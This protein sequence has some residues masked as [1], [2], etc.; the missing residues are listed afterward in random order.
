MNSQNQGT[1]LTAE[2]HRKFRDS[3]DRECLPGTFPFGM[4]LEEV[5]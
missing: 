4:E 5:E 1:A 3:Y 2:L